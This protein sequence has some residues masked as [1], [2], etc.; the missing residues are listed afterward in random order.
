MNHYV[1]ALALHRPRPVH[2][3]CPQ[4]GFTTFQGTARYNRVRGDLVPVVVQACGA[5]GWWR[6]AKGA[7]TVEREP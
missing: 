5:C 7:G 4:C 1:P 6:R 2:G 3:I